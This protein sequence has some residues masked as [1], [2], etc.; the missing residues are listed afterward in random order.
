MLFLKILQ[1]NSSSRQFGTEQI[2]DA[3][4][5]R[6][7]F[8][9]NQKSSV[10]HNSDCDSMWLCSTRANKRIQHTRLPSFDNVK[11]ALYAGD[12]QSSRPLGRA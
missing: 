3:A 7:H 12:K 6:P 5:Q 8:L 11:R 1:L 9:T 2:S 4:A 10:L